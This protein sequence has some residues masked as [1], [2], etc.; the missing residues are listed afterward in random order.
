MLATPEREIYVELSQ[1]SEVK[2]IR[3]AIQ[4]FEPLPVKGQ[5]DLITSFLVCF[6]RHNK[7]DEWGRPEW[8]FFVSDLLQRLRPGGRSH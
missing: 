7:P 5:F 2:V 4:A 3:S 6:N 1:T 8:D